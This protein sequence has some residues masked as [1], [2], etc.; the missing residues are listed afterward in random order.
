MTVIRRSSPAATTDFR[1]TST[2]SVHGASI[3]VGR[4]A[5]RTATEW[6]GYGMDMSGSFKVES[7]RRDSSP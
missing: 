6:R 3:R 2:R 4:N 5:A 1:T 7:R